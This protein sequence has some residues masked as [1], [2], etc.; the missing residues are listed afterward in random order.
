M[1]IQN[2]LVIFSYEGSQISSLYC[3]THFAA[4][5]GE[6]LFVQHFDEMFIWTGAVFH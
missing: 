3:H 2:G 1:K 6:M 4:W 5:F